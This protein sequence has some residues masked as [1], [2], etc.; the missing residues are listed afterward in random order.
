MRLL[1]VRRSPNEVEAIFEEIMADN[2]LK[3]M[4][5]N[6]ATDFR[7]TQNSKHEK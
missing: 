3:L 7:S 2:C 1:K 6:Q 5:D 4:K